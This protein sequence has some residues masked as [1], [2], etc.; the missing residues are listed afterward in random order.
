MTNEKREEIIKS[1]AMDMPVERIAALEDVADADVEQIQYD[2]A[3]EV[4][5]KRKWMKERYG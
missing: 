5:R 1:L 2:Y 4:E 3:N